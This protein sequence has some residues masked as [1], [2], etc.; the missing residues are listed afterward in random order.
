MYT[1]CTNLSS[2]D[3]QFL[4]GLSILSSKYVIEIINLSTF[5]AQLA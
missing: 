1:V 4:S 5:Q 2:N 3:N